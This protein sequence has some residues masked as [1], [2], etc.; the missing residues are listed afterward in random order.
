MISLSEATYI[1]GP[2][3]YIIHV[4][5]YNTYVYSDALE[6]WRLRSSAQYLWTFWNFYPV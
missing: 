1:I 5:L 2:Y 4:G 6:V 3:M